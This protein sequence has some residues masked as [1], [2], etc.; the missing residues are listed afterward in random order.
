MMMLQPSTHADH[1]ACMSLAMAFPH[2]T[3]AVIMFRLIFIVLST[4]WWQEH[5][6]YP[7]FGGTINVTGIT[8]TY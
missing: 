6:V 4:F 7:G 5:Y 2:I 8:R 1:D 3:F